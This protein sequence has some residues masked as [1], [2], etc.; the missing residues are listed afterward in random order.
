MSTAAMPGAQ[1]P[2]A[3]LN[4]QAIDEDPRFQTLH[5][6]KVGFL[7]SLMLFSLFYYFL[8]PIGA[9]YFSDIYRIKVY[10]VV[11]V[12]ILFALSQFVVAWG[13]AFY[14]TAKAKKFDTMAAELVRE[15]DKIGR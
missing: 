10:G 14:Y 12:G 11:N 5:S 7:T 2:R 3:P 9:A 1:A 6:K 8:L 4:W 15:A 13:I